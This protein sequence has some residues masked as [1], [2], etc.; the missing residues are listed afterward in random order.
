[1]GQDVVVLDASVLEEK[2]VPIA[3]DDRR[4]ARAPPAPPAARRSTS[5]TTPTPIRTMGQM[6]T[7]SG[8]TSACWSNS[9]TPIPMS[10]N[11]NSIVRSTRIGRTIPPRSRPYAVARRPRRRR[12]LRSTTANR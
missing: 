3:G 7:P 4:E 10:N 2:P 12:I 8:R 9:R 5:S 6:P 1:V 11:A